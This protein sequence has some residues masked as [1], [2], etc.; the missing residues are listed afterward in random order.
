LD[1]KVYRAE[2]PARVIIPL[3]ESVFP[4]SP[5]IP[6]AIA[7]HQVIRQA[8]EVAGTAISEIKREQFEKVHRELAA[9]LVAHTKREDELLERALASRATTNGEVLLKIARL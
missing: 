3:L 8:M 7:Q 5:E 1:V 4:G 9:A 2:C 6:E